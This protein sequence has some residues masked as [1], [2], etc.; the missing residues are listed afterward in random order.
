MITLYH[1]HSAE[2]FSQPPSNFGGDFWPRPEN[3]ANRLERPAD[4]ESKHQQNR[5]GY[6]RHFHARMKEVDERNNRGHEAADKFDESRSHQI[7]NTF[8]IT[9][10]S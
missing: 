1:A 3:R 2:G 9:H 7:A 4:S 10:N 8:Y 6:D 5:E